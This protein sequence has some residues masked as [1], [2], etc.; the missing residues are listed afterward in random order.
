MRP[1]LADAD[2]LLM[3]MALHATTGDSV[4]MQKFAG[5]F[6]GRALC[7]VSGPPVVEM[8][9]HVRAGY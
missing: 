1:N 7:V 9:T 4:P 6:P 2:E 8:P 3:P 5:E